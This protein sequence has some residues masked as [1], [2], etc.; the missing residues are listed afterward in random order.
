MCL[1]HLKGNINP[2]D[3]TGIKIYIQEKKL[4]DK[5]T[6]K[7]DISVSNS[8]EII[9]HFLVLANNYGW[10]RLAFI[11]GTDTCPKTIYRVVVQIQFADIQKQ[12]H[13]Y[14]VLISIE[15]VDLN[16]LPD[17]LTVSSLTHLSDN[18]ITQATVIYN[19]YDR[20]RSYI[21]S[22]AV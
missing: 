14:F 18:D 12:A 3:P 16:P 2:W 6:D 4:I 13:G 15:N 21:I 10:G 22:K 20:V 7:L 8:K 19:F 5:E 17:N 11:I 1:S 9:D